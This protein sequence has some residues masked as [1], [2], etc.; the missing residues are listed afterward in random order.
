M[1]ISTDPQRLDVDRVHRWLSE[2]SYWAR[3]RPREVTERA[4]AGSLCFG[5]YDDDGAQI[6][7]ARVITDGATFGYLADVFIAAEARRAG[8]GKSIVRAILGHPSVLGLR[9]LTLAT[10]DAHGLYAQFGFG[11]LDDADK[12]MVLRGV[13]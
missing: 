5:A 9:K 4:I 3:G 1:E 10:E 7:F 12:W 13:P 11:P 8:V 2:E 6:G